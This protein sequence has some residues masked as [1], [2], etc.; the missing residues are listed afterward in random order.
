MSIGKNI[1]KG[2]K[3]GIKN[4]GTDFK[5]SKLR[6]AARKPFGSSK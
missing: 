2:A 1:W 6:K 4:M 5:K 3:K